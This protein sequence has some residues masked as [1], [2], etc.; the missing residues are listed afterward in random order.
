MKTSLIRSGLLDFGKRCRS[1]Y[2]QFLQSILYDSFV[3]RLGR[4]G[5]GVEAAFEAVCGC[6]LQ[7][8]WRGA[9]VALLL[10]R[11]ASLKGRGVTRDVCS[12]LDTN[13]IRGAHGRPDCRTAWALKSQRW[14]YDCVEDDTFLPFRLG[15]LRLRS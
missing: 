14:T 5:P 7:T 9:T 3:F 12:G 10:A 8:G 4:P 13:L 2:P 1:G 15:L 11:F 6:D